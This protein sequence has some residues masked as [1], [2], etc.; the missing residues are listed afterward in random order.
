MRGGAAVSA[1]RFKN[2]SFCFFFQKEA[3]GLFR[4]LLGWMDCHTAKRRF[5]MTAWGGGVSL[6]GKMADCI[7]PTII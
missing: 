5:A 6:A 4:I 1:I 3:L 7:R 2:G